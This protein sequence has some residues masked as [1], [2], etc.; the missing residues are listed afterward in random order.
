VVG[1]HPDEAT[2]AIVDYA[3]AHNKP[4]AVVP[5]CVFAAQF[6]GR[7]LKSGAPVATCDQLVGY[8]C[9]KGADFGAKRVF[10][11]FRGKNQVVYGFPKQEAPT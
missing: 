10:L 4:F 2:E 8:L 7:A 5:C 9:E 1:L 11:P 3:L 6:P